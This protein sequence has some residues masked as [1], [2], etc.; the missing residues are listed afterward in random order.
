MFFWAGTFV[1]LGGATIDM[2]VTALCSPDLAREGNYM[3]LMLFEMNAPLWFIYLFLVL[4]EVIMS[5]L[6]VSLWVCF[7]KSYSNM[8][9]RIPYKNL[10][11]TFKWVLGAGK[12]NI[13]D[14][15]LLR[16]FDPYFTISLAAVVAV[17]LQVLHWY[18]ALEWLEFVPISTD[19]RV[20]VLLSILFITIM[21]LVFWT[22]TKLKKSNSVAVSI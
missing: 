18:V 4:L 8:L 16:N 2:F 12:M 5:I 13:L 15:F 9:Y 6:I 1:V 21:T 3:V 7:L 11:T 17:A 10:T 14:F 19:F 22:H 20:S